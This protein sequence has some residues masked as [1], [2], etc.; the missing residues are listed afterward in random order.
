MVSGLKN[1]WHTKIAY[2]LT[3]SLSAA[4]LCQIIKESIKMIC[5]TGFVHRIVFDGASKNVG[6]ANKLGCQIDKLGGSFPHPVIVGE[7]IHVVFDICYII[8]LA[9][10]DYQYLWYQ[11]VEIY[12]GS[13]F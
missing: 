3:N 4:D 12:H 9:F 5:E 10:R 8:K 1:P 11:M 2:F 7:K 6:M 13:I